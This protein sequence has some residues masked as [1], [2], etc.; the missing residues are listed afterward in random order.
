MCILE[1]ITN[2]KIY[3][4]ILDKYKYGTDYIMDNIL[5]CDSYYDINFIPV[6]FLEYFRPIVNDNNVANNCK[7]VWMS[8]L[9]ASLNYIL[10]TIEFSFANDMPLSTE[11]I[12]D[13]LSCDCVVSFVENLIKCMDIDDNE[14]SEFLNSIA[15]L[16]EYEE[17]INNSHNWIF[18][19]CLAAL[20]CIKKEYFDN[21]TDMLIEIMSKEMNELYHERLGTEGDASLKVIKPLFKDAFK[22]SYM[23]QLEK[24][25]DSII[26]RADEEKAKA[27]LNKIKNCILSEP[28]SLVKELNKTIIGQDDYKK[29]LAMA[30]YKHY[31]KATDDSLELK[32]SNMLVIGPTG[33][34]K[35]EVIRQLK[36]IIG[37]VL[38]IIM[39]DASNITKNGWAG[40]NLSSAFKQ[41]PEENY[42]HA[43]VV[44]D[45]FDKMILPQTNS[46]NENISFAMQ[47][48]F[49]AMIEG[50][51][52]TLTNRIINTSNM[53]FICLGAF[54]DGKTEAEE[55]Q[56]H[57]LGFNSVD[58]IKPEKDKLNDFLKR[59]GM[60]DELL[61]RF[62]IICKTSPLFEND[63]FNI[64]VNDNSI[65]SE[66]RKIY[67][68]AGIK[69]IISNELKR[70][71]AHKAYIKGIGARGISNILENVLSMQMFDAKLNDKK[72]VKI[73]DDLLV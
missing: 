71:A 1:Q 31:L 27:E 57:S 10:K 21:C 46:S 65:I 8:T 26:E 69:L 54:N 33:S 5:Y 40:T 13:Q 68:N 43:I 3:A 42:E 62:P 30:L 7:F 24:N 50:G 53:L 70:K 55:R 72:C 60:R 25:I 12:I 36:K 2:K 67:K 73:T 47:S 20:D 14:E 28:V 37:D 48:E 35:T 44:F 66:Y 18:N 23:Q 11:E 41:L 15:L 34:G 19:G 39:I 52:V 6:S 59:Y 51:T 45:E 64:L 16:I 38:P 58:A 22:K 4:E 49:L 32:S 17:K 29:K 56:I 9:I 61:G 63:L